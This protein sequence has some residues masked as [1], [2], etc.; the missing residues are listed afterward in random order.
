M[1]IS[2]KFLQFFVSF[3]YFYNHYNNYNKT[4]NLFE[5]KTYFSKVLIIKFLKQN[6]IFF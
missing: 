1:E 2:I 6:I 4:N 3:D 5:M